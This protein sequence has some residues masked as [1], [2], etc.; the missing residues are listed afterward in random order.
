MKAIE[1]AS[2]AINGEIPTRVQVAHAI[3][4]LKDYPGITGMYTFNSQGDPT[5]VQYYVFKVVSVDEAT[6]DQNII[7]ASYAVTPP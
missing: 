6:W 3:R 1:E 5:L 4:A 2:K 7:A